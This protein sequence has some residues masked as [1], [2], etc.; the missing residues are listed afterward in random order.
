MALYDWPIPGFSLSP[1]LASRIRN[2][3]HD[4]IGHEVRTAQNIDAIIIAL[5]SAVPFELEQDGISQ[6]RIELV[7]TGATGR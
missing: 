1:Q 3:D 4:H 6:G 2:R 7:A 5:E